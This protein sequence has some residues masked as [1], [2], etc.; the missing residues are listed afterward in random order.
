MQPIKKRRKLKSRALT[1]ESTASSLSTAS[2]F[3][4]SS[5]SSFSSSSSSSLTLIPTLKE[6]QG[7]GKPLA[8][9]EGFDLRWINRQKP[10][11]EINK[12]QKCMNDI[13]KQN[14]MKLS[15]AVQG[16]FSQLR[17]FYS[18]D[19]LES[20]RSKGWRWVSSPRTRDN[21]HNHKFYPPAS[22]VTA[23]SNKKIKRFLTSG[24]TVAYVVAM[25]KKK[26]EISN[27]TTSQAM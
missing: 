24:Q 15:N 25:T 6:L 20:I 11:A 27:N 13:A 18:T 2:S 26:L 10:C 23:L 12:C 21:C 8:T 22:T 5:S 14:P 1:P 17:S 3:S 19:D 7:L 9:F 4:S 16:A